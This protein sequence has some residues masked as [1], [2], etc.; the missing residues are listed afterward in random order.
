[1]WKNGK[2][3]S[4]DTAAFSIGWGKHI[5]MLIS[6]WTGHYLWMEMFWGGGG[7]AREGTNDILH[8]QEI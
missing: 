4:R 2:A 5:V 3:K 6:E 1:L 8:E 7:G